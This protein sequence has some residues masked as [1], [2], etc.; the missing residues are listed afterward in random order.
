MSDKTPVIVSATRTPIGKF[1]GGLGSLEATELGGIVIKEAVARALHEELSQRAPGIQVFA[2]ESCHLRGV[3]LAGEPL[4][5]HYC[6][7]HE[8]A[9]S[10][11]SIQ[12]TPTL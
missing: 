6:A 3:T 4:A 7:E 9:P 5:G 2:Y 12:C 1:L 11:D 8:C 10:H